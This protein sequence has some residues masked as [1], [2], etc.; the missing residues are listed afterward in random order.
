MRDL[1]DMLPQARDALREIFPKT[2]RAHVI[3]ITG[4]PGT[5]KSSLVDRLVTRY[6][7]AGQTVGVVAV[8]PTS[9]FSG[10]TILGDRIRMQKHACDPGVFI[11]SMATRVHLGGLSRTTADVVAVMDAMG[12]D[13]VLVE[14]VGVGQDEIEIAALAH[15]VIMVTAPSLEHGDVQAV[16]AGVPEIADVFALNKADRPDADRAVLALTEI[17]EI[18]R[19]S[20]LQLSLRHD[21]AHR[22]HGVQPVSGDAATSWEP[23]VVRTIAMSGEGVDDLASAIERHRQHL[24]T[25]G[26]KRDREV[27]RARAG[28]LALLRDRLLDQALERLSAEAGGLDELSARIAARE[29]DPFDVADEIMARL[30][31]GATR[32]GTTASGREDPE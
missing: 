24:E 30:R 32:E 14:T 2:G 4:E 23:P 1:D 27:R 17:L 21:A 3:G 18:R 22:L 13:V 15:T 6:R 8:D 29:V 9:P 12:K 28:F 31:P 19:S 7:A 20:A 11:R 26:L 5:G 10:G 16:K 25:T